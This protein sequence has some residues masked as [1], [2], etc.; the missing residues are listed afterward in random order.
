MRR[1]CPEDLSAW[2]EMLRACSPE[3]IWRRFEGHSVEYLLARAQELCG[4]DPEHEVIIVAELEGKIVGESRLCVIPGKQLAEFCVLVADPWQGLGLGAQ[5]TEAA[6][7]VARGLG[8]RR[9]LVEVVPDNPRIIRFL[10]RRGFRF[11]IH[12]DGRIFFGE[13]NLD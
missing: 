7:E 4:C 11:P 6:L 8:L 5:L 10:S 3:S 12:S 13:K 2:C 1:F 9:V